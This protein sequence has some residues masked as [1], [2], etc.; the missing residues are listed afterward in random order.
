MKK[1]SVQKIETVLVASAAASACFILCFFRC[2]AIP[3]RSAR[4]AY[5]D[6]KKYGESFSAAYTQEY[7]ILLNKLS[8]TPF[9]T[10]KK[11]T[12]KMNQYHKQKS[13]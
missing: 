10:Y 3:V 7:D 13:R 11:Y 4:A 9:D 2:W 5:R 12:E 1:E 8:N 6:V